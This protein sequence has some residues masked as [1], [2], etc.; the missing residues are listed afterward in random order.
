MIQINVHTDSQHPEGVVYVL[1]EEG[2]VR[3][4]VPCQSVALQLAVGCL[5]SAQVKLQPLNLKMNRVDAELYVDLG[6]RN[7]RLVNEEKFDV[8]G[9]Q[10]GRTDTSVFPDAD[11]LSA[12]QRKFVEYLRGIRLGQRKD[13]TYGE[14]SVLMEI[15]DGVAKPPEDVKKPWTGYTKAFLYGDHDHFIPVVLYRE[16]MQTQVDV[17]DVSHIN[18]ITDKQLL[19]EEARLGTKKVEGQK[20]YSLWL[21]ACVG[22]QKAMCQKFGG[23][24]P[25]PGPVPFENNDLLSPDE[26]AFVELTRSFGGLDG[27]AIGKAL[28][29]IDRLAPNSRRKSTVNPFHPDSKAR[30]DAGIKTDTPG[31]V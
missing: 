20:D 17:A 10:S 16:N 18:R 29:V 26:R 6:G 11:P 30:A 23:T 4:Q 21:Y 24:Y 15:L 8:V 25:E 27:T 5:P 1:D 12:D 19:A 3:C 22:F 28:A 7:Y 13:P 9:K 14:L 2:K 31:G